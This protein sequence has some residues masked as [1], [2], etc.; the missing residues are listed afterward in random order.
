MSSV[1]SIEK[2]GKLLQRAGFQVAN[3]LPSKSCF[4]L[5][6]RKD[7]R[8]MLLKVLSNVDGLKDEQGRELRVLARLLSATPLVVGEKTRRSEM[9]DG[10]VYGRCGV[11]TINF[12]TFK[13]FILEDVRPVALARRG[14]LYIRI[15]GEALRRAR[16]EKGLS[17]GNLAERVG[18]SRKA[19]YEYERNE[20]DATLETAL[21]IEDE[22]DAN[23]IIP[24]DLSEW[25]S[26]YDYEK[27]E[28]E[29]EE[30]EWEDELEREVFEALSDL[31][32]KVILARR[33]P[34]D[35]LTADQREKCLVVTGVG[36]ASERTIER[37]I[38][39]LEKLSWV[40]QKLAMFV[41]DKN[42]EIK[43]TRVP[44]FSKEEI[45]SM[46]EPKELLRRVQ[47]SN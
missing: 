7:D 36:R 37:R 21:K 31:G 2:V 22:L 15:D 35:A 47:M 46:E 41:V 29:E 3:N 44:V 4:D 20:M 19:I 13:R 14:G 39:V 11:P 18:V 43:G 12:S 45:E 34:F 26:I 38:M 16:E 24:V 9:L 10:V 27:E 28:E 25:Y 30:Q 1:L 8:L 6:A 33:A 40:A 23:V 32:F 5:V 42:K 17:L